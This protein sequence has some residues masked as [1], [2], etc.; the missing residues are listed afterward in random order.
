MHRGVMHRAEGSTV[1]LL[2]HAHAQVPWIHTHLLV[3]PHSALDTHSRM[4]VH[5][6]TLHTQHIRTRTHTL[7]HAPSSSA[8][9]RSPARG[10]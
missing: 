6:W 5:K 8:G 9:P 7:R 4:H 3:R 2:E 1:H 10:S